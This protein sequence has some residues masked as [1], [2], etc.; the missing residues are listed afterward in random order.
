MDA[1]GAVGCR[2]CRADRANRGRDLV[3]A[4]RAG[5]NP[6]SSRSGRSSAALPRAGGAP[7]PPRARWIRSKSA[8][9]EIRAGKMVI[10]LDDEDRENEGDLVM[11][12]EKVTPEAINFMRKE[13]RRPDLRAAAG[14]AARRAADPEHGARQH[15]AARHGVLGLGRSAR[16][17]RRPASRRTTAPARSKRC[18]IRTRRRPTS[19]A[20]ATRFRCA[21]AK[22][23]C[24]CAPG[25]PRRRSISRGSPGSIPAGVICEIMDD[26]GTMMRLPR[27]R[28]FARQAR[29]QAGDRART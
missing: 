12:A 11:A 7:R 18:S 2:A 26:D 9:A 20:R 25:R 15:R 19:C 17:R 28:E 8:I 14:D 3:P 22:A 27:L 6:R 5:A 10:V 13:G 4:A 1:A 21:R 16:P 29:P 24:S 23:A